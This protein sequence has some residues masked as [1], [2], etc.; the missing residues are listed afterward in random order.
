MSE[1]INFQSMPSYTVL[2]IL[3]AILTIG[4]IGSIPLLGQ[5][6]VFPAVM[7]MFVA[8]GFAFTAYIFVPAPTAETY[9][10]LKQQLLIFLLP[11]TAILMFSALFVYRGSLFYWLAMTMAIA[12]TILYKPPKMPKLDIKTGIFG[13]FT[14]FIVVILISFL[15][16]QF[17]I[18]SFHQAIQLLQ[19]SWSP[20]QLDNQGNP[21]ALQIN[22]LE[23][24][25]IVAMGEELWARLTMG[26]G[27]TSLVGPRTAWLWSTF[28]FL[29][30]HTPSRLM[31]L[32][33]EPWLVPVVIAILGAVLIPFFIFY[34]KN[35]NIFTGII[36][37]ATYN[38]LLS[39]LQYGTLI[40]DIFV[41]GLLIYITMK[42][43]E[44]NIEITVPQIVKEVIEK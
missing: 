41:L 2:N 11:S 36:M 24:F 22:A 35:P 8:L 26:Y 3:A 7:S 32:I 44:T 12:F 16:D 34:R 31:M 20:I 18:L 15:L 4:L 42:I 1:E 43:T 33:F 40:L 39:G 37:H 6:W 25:L 5:I 30:L 14:M 27:A 17:K 23:M 28:W 38:T 29:Y 13:A 9:G 19:L 21:L 10:G